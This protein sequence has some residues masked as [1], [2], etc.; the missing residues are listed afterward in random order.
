MKMT[1]P[2]MAHL[3]RVRRREL[4]QVGLHDSRDSKITM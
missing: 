4:L 1:A 3:A 2:P